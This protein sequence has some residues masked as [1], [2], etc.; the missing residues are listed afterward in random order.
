MAK[1]E[2]MQMAVHP[3]KVLIKI[4]KQEWNDLFS[5]WVTRADG[6]RVQLF[7]DVEESEGFERR[8]KQNVSV[9]NII[10]AGNSVSGIMKGDVAIID[11]LVTGGSDALVGYHFNNMVVA[12]TAHTTYHD[13]DSR[14][15]ID[16]RK[17]WKKGDYDY[18]SPLLGVVRMGKIKAFH[19]YVF[20]K[21]E[22][23]TKMS[24]AESGL[25][26]EETD[27]VCIREVL[28]AHPD[29]GLVDGDKVVIKE[30]NL[31]S[32]FIDKKEISVIFEEDILMKV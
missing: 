9:G 22:A 25:L 8:F 19:P 4:T 30:G 20:L 26:K 24:V 28:A 32:R 13:K 29:S 12:I 31:F 6:K 27:D 21:Y 3:K 18:L 7:T 11:Y 16:G 2:M 14:P 5:I 17:T 10:A 23:A 15:M 1:K